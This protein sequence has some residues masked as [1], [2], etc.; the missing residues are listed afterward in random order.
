MIQH[1]LEVDHLLPECLSNQDDWEAFNFFSLHQ[2]R[3][4]YLSTANGIQQ[5][6]WGYRY[7]SNRYGVTDKGI[8]NACAAWQHWLK[9]GWH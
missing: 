5:I 1:V 4:K 7:I 3:S 2:G 6:Q 8:P 9:K